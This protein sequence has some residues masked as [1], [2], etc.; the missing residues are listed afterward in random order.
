MILQDTMQ[1]V[2][3]YSAFKVHSGNKV[4][5][6]KWMHPM[7]YAYTFFGLICII[8]LV[9]NLPVPIGRLTPAASYFFNIVSSVTLPTPWCAVFP[10]VCREGISVHHKLRLVCFFCLFVCFCFVF[11][12]LNVLI[13]PILMGFTHNKIL[14][15]TAKQQSS[16]GQIYTR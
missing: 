8:F 15:H 14:G 5:S 11:F 6:G 9:L 7:N 4:H 1:S 2:Q 3:E 16:V 13:K 12:V 10:C